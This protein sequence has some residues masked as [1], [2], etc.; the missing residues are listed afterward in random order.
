[1]DNDKKIMLCALSLSRI[2]QDLKE[3]AL[4]ETGIVDGAAVMVLALSQHLASKVREIPEAVLHNTDT[5]STHN[6][7]IGE[8]ILAINDNIGE[9]IN[10]V[11]EQ[12]KNENL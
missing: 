3:L 10:A 7:K 1:M 2:A 12:I 6:T 5:D 4:E 11:A 9:E 8:E